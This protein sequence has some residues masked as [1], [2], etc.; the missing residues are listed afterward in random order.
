MERNFAGNIDYFLGVNE[1]NEAVYAYGIYSEADDI[2][3][4]YL[5]QIT[6]DPNYSKLI[7]MEVEGYP[8]YLI[9]RYRSG[10]KLFKKSI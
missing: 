3:A 5:A 9:Y 4:A 6:T 10:R 1:L 8:A 7:S 2:A